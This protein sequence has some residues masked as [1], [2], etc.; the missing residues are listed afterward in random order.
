MDG[1][2][3]AV[4]KQCNFQLFDKQAFSAHFCQRCIKDHIA[5]RH[6]RN[7]FDTQTRMAG[8]EALL[9]ILCLP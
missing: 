2:I 5:A 4:L 9:N 3:G 8:F 7:Q 1:D 6:H